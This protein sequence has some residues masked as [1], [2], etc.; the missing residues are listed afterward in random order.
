[1]PQAVIRSGLS[2]LVKAEKCLERDRAESA[3]HEQRPMREID[4]A[5]RAENERQ[6]KRDQRIGATLVQAVQKL[7]KNG[8]H[9][10][11]SSVIA[12]L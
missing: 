9:G 5:Q 7:K 1:M 2:D 4:D 3:Q 8:I 11:P 6:A 12:T 10:L